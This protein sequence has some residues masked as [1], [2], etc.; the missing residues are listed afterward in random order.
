LEKDWRERQLQERNK[1]D[2]TQKKYWRK[3]EEITCYEFDLKKILILFQA[4]LSRI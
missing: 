4:C 1:L 2:E 3:V